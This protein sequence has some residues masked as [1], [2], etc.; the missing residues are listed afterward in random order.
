M[1]NYLLLSDDE[2]HFFGW[3]YRVEIIGV[4]LW[5]TR[6]DKAG[7]VAD[8]DHMKIGYARV[9]TLEQHLGG[10]IES[11]R[12]AGCQKI[13]DEKISAA[14]T[15]RRELQKMM[16]KLERDDVVVVTR[17]DRLCRNL[18]DMLNLLHELSERGIS[19]YSLK[20]EWANLDSAS[21]KLLLHILSATAKFERELIKSRVDE[22]RKRAMIKGVK[23]GRPSKLNKNQLHKMVEMLAVGKNQEECAVIFGVN[24]ST[25]SYQ[26]KK[27]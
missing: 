5:K 26:L 2:N 8:D 12:A 13:Y 21:G 25:I 6:I 10:Q 16:K 19:F 22:G 23:F 1:G 27:I 9:S 17:L 14:T 3:K 4:S 20:E 11:L 18:R 24:Q 15:S 7:C